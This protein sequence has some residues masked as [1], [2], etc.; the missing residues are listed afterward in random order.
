MLRQI[1]V[2]LSLDETPAVACREAGIS[3][4]SYY[5][6]RKEY[7][8]L[9]LDQAKRMKELERENVRLRR[10]AADL[11]LE[12]QVFKDGSLGKL[13][14]P[15]RRRQAVEGIRAKYG[16]SERHACRIV[17]PTERND[18]PLSFEPMKMRRRERSSRRHV[19]ST[20][21][22]KAT[23]IDFERPIFR[24]VNGLSPTGARYPIDPALTQN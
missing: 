12:K 13:V 23:H 14:G 24:E 22:D 2:L 10:L 11:S 8:R 5:R 17:D 7:G 21:S 1:E 6:W 15:E 20:L 4:Q 19:D 3:Q 16:L 9:E 18:T